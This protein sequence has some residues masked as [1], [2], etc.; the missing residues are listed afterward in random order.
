M[1]LTDGGFRGDLL[2][3]SGHV[4]HPD[5]AVAIPPLSNGH[6]EEQVVRLR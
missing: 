4:K 6:R 5:G 2:P 3:H 1:M